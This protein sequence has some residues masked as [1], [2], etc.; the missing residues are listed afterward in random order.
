MQTFPCDHPKLQETRFSVAVVYENAGAGAHLYLLAAS[1]YFSLVSSG[2]LANA[3]ASPSSS[4]RNCGYAGGR[5][6]TTTIPSESGLDPNAFSGYN[7]INITFC[8]Q[9]M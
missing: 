6:R 7:N 1:A 3:F 5:S 2:K 8:V 9:W 4:F